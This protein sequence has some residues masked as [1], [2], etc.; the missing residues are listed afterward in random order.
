MIIRESTASDDNLHG[1]QLLAYRQV[2][3]LLVRGFWCRLHERAD[4]SQFASQADQQAWIFAMQ[5]SIRTRLKVLF[6]SLPQILRFIMTPEQVCAC[7]TWRPS[8]ARAD[9]GAFQSQGR[10]HHLCRLRR[11]ESNA[12]SRPAWRARVL[13]GMQSARVASQL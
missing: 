5:L 6:N 13:A 10:Q 4:M 2:M 8:N 1:A 3:L 9:T 7:P 11:T 12:H